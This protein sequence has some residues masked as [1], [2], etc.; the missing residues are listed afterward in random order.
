[1]NPI[2]QKTA[3]LCK[4]TYYPDIILAVLPIYTILFCS[5]F[6]L[7]TLN[8]TAV[9][10]FFA[11]LHFLAVVQVFSL[12][13]GEKQI[14]IAPNKIIVIL[15]SLKMLIRNSQLQ[16]NGTDS[17]NN[18]KIRYIMNAHRTMNRRCTINLP[19]TV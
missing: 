14:F 13:V 2:H 11:R 6:S 4:Q 19:F 12:L 16:K 3:F 18:P 8:F 1:M 5:F 9:F 17:T 10:S 15:N 7:P